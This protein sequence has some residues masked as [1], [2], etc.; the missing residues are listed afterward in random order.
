MQRL[1]VGIDREHG[2]LVLD[3]IVVG[4]IGLVGHTLGEDGDL[5]VLELHQQGVAGARIVLTSVVVHDPALGGGL[6]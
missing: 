5:P 2:A 6:E 3:D 4:G 1:V